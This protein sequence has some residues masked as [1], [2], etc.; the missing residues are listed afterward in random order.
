VLEG[1]LTLFHPHNPLLLARDLLDIAIVAYAVYRLLLLLRGTRAMQVGLG[2]ALIVM[3]YVVAQKAG[4]ATA[5][6]LLDRFLASFLLLVVVIFQADIRRA[7]MRVG[8]RPFLL[9]WRKAE[10]TIAVE[11]VIHASA[12]L[13]QR[14]IGA[15]IVFEREASLDDFVA[16][17]T[18]L[19]ADVSRELLYTAFLPGYENPLHDGAV[20]IKNARVWKAGAFLPL[21]A[22]P[23]LDRT[24][25]TR[26]RA[27][28]GISE[29]TDAVVVIV[30]EERGQISLC[31]DGNI[32]R[33]L[34]E[35]S[36]RQ[37][38]Y[39]LFYTK[40]KAASLLKSAAGREPEGR[41][42]GRATLSGAHRAVPSGERR[43]TEP[44][45][46]ARPVEPGPR[47]E[48]RGGEEAAR[49]RT[50]RS[51]TE[52]RSLPPGPRPAASPPKPAGEE[53]G[54]EPP[55]RRSTNPKE[56]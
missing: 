2:L 14:R 32:V 29:E 56:V 33:G 53:T 24:L 27:A 46:A 47:L 43:A 45:K 25:G 23:T 7:L 18:V 11:E 16:Q 12:L 55:T 5:Y 48:R 3:V 20:I 8:N 9:R 42:E 30:S 49:E 39:G 13:A 1:L 10:E 26:H 41:E 54:P 35:Q 31:F 36:L 21:T 44:G 37:A 51:G 19:D 22:N 52:R 50:P 6:T 17:G 4:L 40:R 38:L 15:L 34:N 28:L